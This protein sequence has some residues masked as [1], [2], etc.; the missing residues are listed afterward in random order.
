M[1]FVELEFLTHIGV[2]IAMCLC[3]VKINWHA[4]NLVL[5]VRMCQTAHHQA[6]VVARTTR[7]F[8]LEEGSV[9]LMLIISDL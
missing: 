7:M 3:Q 2:G 9:R 1:D 5:P 4:L 6:W 8:A